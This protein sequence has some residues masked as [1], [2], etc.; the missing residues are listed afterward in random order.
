MSHHDRAAAFENR[1]PVAS[2]TATVSDDHAL[3][4]RHTPQIRFDRLE[5][6]LPAV[7]GYTIF[8]E[9]ARSVSFPREI[10]LPPNAELVIEYAIWWDWDIQ[11]LYE[12]EHVWVYLDAAE[13]IILAEASWHGGHN[14][15]WTEEGQ[16]PLENGRLTLYA[17]PGKHAL[18][19]SPSWLVKR[20]VATRRDCGPLAGVRGLHVT[21]V[22]APHLKRKRNPLVNWLVRAYLR[23]QVFEPSFEFSL[24]V[25]T[26]SLELVPWDV[27]SIWIPARIAWWTRRLYGLVLLKDSREALQGALSNLTE[28]LQIHAEAFSLDCPIKASVRR[29]KR[30]AVLQPV[31]HTASAV[32]AAYM[33]TKQRGWLAG[34]KFLDGL[35]RMGV[36]QRTLFA[37]FRSDVIDE[38]RSLNLRFFEP[39]SISLPEPVRILN[40]EYVEKF[41]R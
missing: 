10:I 12:L 22:L 28:S 16:V 5:P 39:R 32:I 8:R 29:Q 27:L 33:G 11:H 37:E 20:S 34:Q 19:P 35:H 38:V 14:A 18:A 1:L 23:Q 41:L 6:F 26:L 9:N 2:L 24:V 13:N 3:A 21:P 17:E 4:S 15:M 7:V 36:R 31:W 40:D 25:D 30:G